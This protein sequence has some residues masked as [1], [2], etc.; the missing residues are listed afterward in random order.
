MTTEELTTS[1]YALLWSQSQGAMH[2]E[3][4]ADMLDQNREAC[5]DD[6][7]MDYVP[8]AFGSEEHCRE[9]AEQ[10]RPTLHER[11]ERKSNPQ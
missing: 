1:D 6:R 2:I 4:I 8:I 3:P 9:A 5:A 7:R 11:Q 10:V